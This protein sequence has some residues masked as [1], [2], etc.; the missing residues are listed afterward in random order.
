M[1]DAVSYDPLLPVTFLD[2]SALVYP[3]KPA[4][5]YRDRRISYGEMGAR[6]NRLAAALEGLGLG[7]GDR[8]AYLA[9]NVPAMLEGKFG[10]QRIGAIIVPLNIRLAPR[11]SPTS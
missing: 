7:R 4:I 10:P 9:P 3:D 11:R 2:R 5:I 8:V 1:P 6:S